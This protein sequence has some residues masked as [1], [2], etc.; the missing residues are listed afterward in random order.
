[1]FQTGAGSSDGRQVFWTPL[2][3]GQHQAL[4]TPGELYNP[5][6][7]PDGKLAAIEVRGE[8]NEGVDLWLVD[9]A[10]AGSGHYSILAS[11]SE[12]TPPAVPCWVP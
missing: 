11:F 12:T 7:S 2:D 5:S 8:S 10:A 6:I 1:M 4:G 3:G 9:R